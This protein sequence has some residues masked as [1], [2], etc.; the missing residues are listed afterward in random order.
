[1][2][3]PENLQILSQV[4]FIGFGIVFLI[5]L[6]MA[7]N[8]RTLTVVPVLIGYLAGARDADTTWGALGKTIAFVL[9]MTVADVLLGVLFALL[10]N[11]VSAV[12]GPKWEFV[13]GIV[14]ILL[15]LRWLNFLKFRT[16]GFEM[17]MR[18]AGGM[19][20]AFFLGFPFSMSFCPFCVPVVLS[21][22]TIAAATGHVWYSAILML[23]FSLGRGIPLIVA[24]VS[25]GTVKRM[26]KF[27]SYIPLVER[28][29]GVLLILMG[30]YYFYDVARLYIAIT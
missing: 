9:G 8:P 1:M 30:L 18:R 19:V 22:L 16:I 21:M 14:L 15:G 11:G 5:G 27:R 20:S 28:L 26:E 25:F 29:G 17:K 10:G 2:F 23:F 7:F 4:S 3:E 13:I 12:F 6:A 24:G